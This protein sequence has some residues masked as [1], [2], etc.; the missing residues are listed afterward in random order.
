[1]SNC[2]VKNFNIIT[3][4]KSQLVV[5]QDGETVIIKTK[6]NLS[7]YLNIVDLKP[8]YLPLVKKIK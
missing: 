6:Y 5:R 1:M 8:L 3:L 4:K 7:K 2:A